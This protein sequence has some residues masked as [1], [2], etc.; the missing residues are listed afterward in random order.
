MSEHVVSPDL[1]QPLALACLLHDGVVQPIRGHKAVG[2][3]PA[4]PSVADD[5]ASVPLEEYCPIRFVA[6]R[7]EIRN[8]VIGE[9]VELAV[10]KSL[11]NGESPSIR[12]D[13]QEI[14]LDGAERRPDP[15]PVLSEVVPDEDHLFFKVYSISSN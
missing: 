12:D 11:C 15:V 1:H 6:V 8:M 7:G 14:L 9:L 10:D 3:V 5:V 2:P 4:A 13:A